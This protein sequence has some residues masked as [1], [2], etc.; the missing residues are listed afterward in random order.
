MRVAMSMGDRDNDDG[1]ALDTVDQRVGKPVEKTSSNFRFDLF[2]CEGVCLYE[3]YCSIESIKESHTSPR[4][5]PFEPDN[6]VGNVLLS[7]CEEP[8]VHLLLILTHQLFIRNTRKPSLF[9]CFPAT[10]RFVSPVS[11]DLG[12]RLMQ[13]GEE[14]IEHPNLFL[15]RQ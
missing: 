15:I 1:R 4:L 12:I 5:S 11:V 2:A 10:A 9:I 14:R 6:S 13:I 8:D 3:S 7:E